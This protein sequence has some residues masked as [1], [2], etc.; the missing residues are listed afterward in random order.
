MLVFECSGAQLCGIR[1]IQWLGI[2]RRPGVRLDT[3][4]RV[5]DGDAFLIGVVSVI[6]TESVKRYG[7]AFV[8][9]GARRTISTI[10]L[11]FQAPPFRISSTM[12]MVGIPGAFDIG[13]VL[14]GANVRRKAAI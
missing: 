5:V 12:L 4:K 6:F 10:H 9:Q 2:E 1:N 3:I 8:P 7:H 14:F 13:Y 11:S